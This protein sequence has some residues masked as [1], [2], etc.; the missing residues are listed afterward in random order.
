L[1]HAVLYRE[2]R[3]ISNKL[4]YHQQ[5]SF[6]GKARCRK[7]REGVGHGPYWYSYQTTDGRTVRQYIGKYLPDSVRAGAVLENQQ[8][9]KGIV[10]VLQEGQERYE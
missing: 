3:H 4:T 9:R 8:K 2:L 6:C 7:C 1:D 10:V 5:V